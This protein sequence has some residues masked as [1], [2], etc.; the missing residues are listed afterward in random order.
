[1]KVLV[2][3]PDST[4]MAVGPP[5]I[6]AALKEAGHEVSGH[7]FRSEAAFRS[8]VRGN[9]VVA[10][11]GL[12]S[13]FKPVKRMLEIAK[14]GGAHTVVG[15][16]IVSSEPELMTRELKPDYSVLGQGEITACELMRLIEH[17]GD[18]ESV[19]GIAYLEGDR[20]VQTPPRVDVD[21]LDALPF[22]DYECFGYLKMLD[23]MRPSDIDW[24]DGFDYP[25]DYQLIASRACPYHCSFCYHPSG[26]NYRRR[27]IDSIMAELEAVVPK[28]RINI[29]SI[30]D[31]LFS[32]DEKR[33]LEFCERF[34]ELRART[35]WEVKW[36]CCMHVRGLKLETLKVMRQSGSDF[37][38]FGFESYSRTVLDSMKKRAT[39]EQIHY[40]VHAALDNRMAIQSNFIFGDRAETWETA[41]ET[42]TFWREHKEASIFLGWL[43]MCPNSPDYQYCVKTGVIKNRLAHVRDNL[44]E[45]VNMT[46]MPDW[47]FYRLIATVYLL[48]ITDVYWVPP[49]RKL[50]NSLVVKCPHCHETITYGNYRLPWA[51]KQRVICRACHKRFYIGPRWF[52]LAQKLVALV[53]P[54]HAWSY[55]AYNWCRKLLHY[56]RGALGKP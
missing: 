49:L 28:Y 35:P 40:A 34:R 29:V 9:Q 16:G 24:R 18:A 21:D 33:L 13:Q 43:I 6:A 53:V 32:V 4:V 20:F 22:P 5:C 38:A 7:I 42:I 19:S 47:E 27:S 17:G 55:Y 10:V 23:E 51:Y 44:F 56:L 54:R 25:R 15:G 8:A 45:V 41:R 11:G 48:N 52:I 3:M 2:A 46:A 12:C 30:L 14:E 31:D 36:W 1:M 39:P 37:V 50:K 26:Y